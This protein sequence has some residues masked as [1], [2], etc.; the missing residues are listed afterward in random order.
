MAA[1]A[2]VSCGGGGGGGGGSS[3]GGN[4]LQF[5]ADTSA[6]TFDVNP[7]V[8]TPS[9]T[10][11]ITATGNYSDTIYVVATATGQGL[12]ASIPITVSGRTARAV[13]SA[14]ESLPPGTYT[15][16]LNL[17]ACSD[18]ACKSQI[19]NSPLV[20][21]FTVNVHA[22]LQLSPTSLVANA[23]SGSGVSQVVSIQLPSG[24]SSASATVTSGA[25]FVTV[26]FTTATGLTVTLASLPSGTYTGS[27]TIVAGSSSAVLP[28][29]YSVSPPPGGDVPMAVAPGSLTMNTVENGLTSTTLAVTPPSWNPQVTATVEYPAGAASGWLS[30]SA[31]A[32]GFQ[33]NA[34]ATGLLAGAYTATVRVHGAYPATDILVP[35]ALTVGPGLVRPADVLVNVN[36]ESTSAAFS[37]SVPV[38]LA[39]G[40]AVNWTASANVPWLGFTKG[41]GT[42]GQSLVYQ[43]DAAQFAA[44][45][46]AAQYPATITLTPA[47]STMTPVSFSLTLSKQLPQITSLAPYTQVAGQT[48]RVVL[49]GS[50]FSG[51]T[52]P[53]A[54]VLIQGSTPASVSVV[55]DTEMVAN[56]NALSAG[57]HV[58]SVSNALGLA[59][60]TRPVA[61][62]TPVPHTY[63]ATPTGANI[64]TL[65]YDAEREAVFA[66]NSDANTIMRFTPG[67]SGTW[68]ATSVPFASVG[69]IGL[70]IDGSRLIAMT[71]LSASPAVIAT[72][73]PTTLA[74][75]RSVTQSRTIGPDFS[76]LGFGLST[77]NDGR[78]WLDLETP[79]PPFSDLA[80]TT[81][82]TLTANVVSLPSLSTTFYDGP[83][84]AHSRDGER[85]LIVQS[86]AITPQPPMLYL[87]AADGVVH[88][89]PAGLTFSY[90]FS[91][92]D[93][94]DRVVFDA[95][96]LRDRNFNL[97]GQL[98]IPAA[99]A[100]FPIDA[101]VSPDGTRIYALSYPNSAPS[102]TPPP[103]VYVF[104]ATV[105]QPSL[106]ILGYFTINDYPSCP[107]VGSTTPCTNY[108]HASAISIDGQTLYYAGQQN[109]VVVPT[110]TPLV[111]GPVAPAT[112]KFLQ[113][114]A[115]TPWPLNLH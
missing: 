97:L 108:N 114:R 31:V 11:T 51:I 53:S 109:F 24:A 26:N 15:G 113:R 89:N 44:L 29:S 74:T 57:N 104:D 46:N 76:L 47:S 3:S 102:G 60:S 8:P 25:G 18:A 33:V 10:V 38:T 112:V 45:A 22:P 105:A 5:S 17:M 77:T 64:R 35:V 55:N 2:L 67:S 6:L 13:V 92:S 99:D 78:T 100:Y 1:L 34:N 27:V 7:G 14:D 52:N 96:S 65:A 63:A 39:A 107:V 85:L 79:Q 80:Y 42:T 90:N 71:T 12:A 87:D 4:G 28:I 88:Q 20:L 21:S 82:D 98:A 19:G 73:D 54:R 36:A 66:A 32:G 48:A 59:T 81:V 86:A 62:V 111:T 23:T 110:N 69:E 37:G 56:F 91:L 101:L 93:T 43:I 83:W 41:S 72:L 49:R 50:G 94:G 106:P 68:S 9:Q 58:V 84:F 70:S 95:T 103:R 61:A 75:T 40:P 30:T 16:K 115:P